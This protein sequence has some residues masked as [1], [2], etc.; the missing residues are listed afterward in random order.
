MVVT[1]Y[2]SVAVWSAMGLIT[3]MEEKQ[4]SRPSRRRK[5]SLPRIWSEECYSLNSSLRRLVA[6]AMAASGVRDKAPTTAPC[7]NKY[8]RRHISM[9]YDLH[10]PQ[11][12]PLSFS[13]CAGKDLRDGAG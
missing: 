2:A 5:W 3:V 7:F 6:S 1:E 8:G 4:M 12:V 11:K 13:S 10:V 9:G